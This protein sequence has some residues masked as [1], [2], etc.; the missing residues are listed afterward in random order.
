MISEIS[1]ARES[2]FEMRD[3]V[4]KLVLSWATASQQAWILG[5]TRFPE[6]PLIVDYDYRRV[7][8]LAMYENAKVLDYTVVA[9]FA[10]QAGR[11]CLT[12]SLSTRF[13]FHKFPNQEATSREVLWDKRIVGLRA[14]LPT[15]AWIIGRVE[16]FMDQVS[17]SVRGR[18]DGGRQDH[19]ETIRTIFDGPDQSVL[20]DELHYLGLL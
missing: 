14:V 5:K 18:Q 9:Y 1:A 20:T 15:V 6:V 4:G 10:S 8:V 12:P 7:S 11:S 17:E 13:M 3:N 2:L 19:V 16:K